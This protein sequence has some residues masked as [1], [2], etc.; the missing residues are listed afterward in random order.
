MWLLFLERHGITA[1][2]LHYAS[3]C[4]APLNLRRITT[5]PASTSTCMNMVLWRHLLHMPQV[6]KHCLIKFPS[7]TWLTRA[8]LTTMRLEYIFA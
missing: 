1:I 5:L 3:A 7:C 2:G 6:A 4:S 8:V